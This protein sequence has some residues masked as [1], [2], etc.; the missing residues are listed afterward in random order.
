MTITVPGAEILSEVDGAD[1]EVPGKRRA[2]TLLVDDG[3]LLRHL[4][5][6]VLQ[7]G[8]IGIERR[9]AHRLHLELLLVALVGDLAQ[10]RHGLAAIRA[11]RRRR[12]R[13]A[14]TAARLPRRRR[15]N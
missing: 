11:W 1:A 3:L 8:G 2:Q 5:L 7:I 10:I 6:G 4:R 9:L 15:R 13:A 14:S 12:P